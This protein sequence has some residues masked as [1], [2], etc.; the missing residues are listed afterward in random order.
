MLYY[1]Y[2]YSTVFLILLLMVYILSNY[3]LKSADDCC[4]RE[5]EIQDSVDRLY[6]QL[7]PKVI[8]TIKRN[9][10]PVSSSKKKASDKEGK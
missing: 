8:D 5:D 6:Q 1:I 4:C 2:F 10:P 3:Y 7:E 9:L